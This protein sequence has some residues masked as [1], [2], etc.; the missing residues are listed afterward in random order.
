MQKYVC[1][2]PYQDIRSSKVEPQIMHAYVNGVS[3]HAHKFIWSNAE[4]GLGIRIW[5]RI[6]FCRLDR[7][8]GHEI[9]KVGKCHVLDCLMSPFEG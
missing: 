7:G 1:F 6:D 2:L 5:I 4:L 9:E 3:E 8:G